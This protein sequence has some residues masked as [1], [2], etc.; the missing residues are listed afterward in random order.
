MHLKPVVVG[1][2]GARPGDLE[3]SEKGE[4]RLA[5]TE[6]GEQASETA[7]VCRQPGGGNPRTPPSWASDPSGPF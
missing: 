1:W 3:E 4:R 7:G 5:G 2:A 6:E